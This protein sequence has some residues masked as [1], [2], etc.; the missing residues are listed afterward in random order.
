MEHSIAAKYAARPAARFVHPSS[1]A[2][3]RR[4]G[5]RVAGSF[6]AAGTRP[7]VLRRPDGS[8]LAR[9]RG[10]WRAFRAAR[11]RRATDGR[12]R[13]SITMHWA[14]SGRAGTDRRSS[15]ATAPWRG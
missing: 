5:L 3:E 12:P 9:L 1:R 15:A 2:R 6:R 11:P 14:R 13:P 10:G 4:L 7:T 8:V